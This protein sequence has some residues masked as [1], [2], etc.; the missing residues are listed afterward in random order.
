MGDI[1]KNGMA[2]IFLPNGIL[3]YFEITDFTQDDFRI[4]IYLEE[5]NILPSGASKDEHETKDFMASTV[6]QDFP[7]RG[8]GLFLH[9][10]RRRWRHKNTGKIIKRDWDLVM[11]GGQITKEFAAFLK[12]LGG[13]QS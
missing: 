8:K 4:D 3:D 10:S 7:I 11:D 13:V 12:E 5:Q 1:M 6:V 9:I 2:E